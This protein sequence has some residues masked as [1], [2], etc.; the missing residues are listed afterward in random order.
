MLCDFSNQIRKVRPKW[1]PKL[2]VTDFSL[3]YLH[4]V[5]MALN[6]IPLDDYINRKDDMLVGDKVDKDPATVLFVCTGHFLHFVRKYMRQNT[7]NQEAVF[8][9]CTHLVN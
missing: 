8:M 1:E 6:E 4:A 5:S 7:L 2:V 3:A 9:Q